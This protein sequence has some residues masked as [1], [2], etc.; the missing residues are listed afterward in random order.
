MIAGLL[1]TRILIDYLGLNMLGQLGLVLSISNILVSVGNAISGAISRYFTLYINKDEKK[2]ATIISSAIALNTYLFFGI[3]IFCL[4]ISDNIFFY[5]I[6]LFSF[7]LNQ[8]SGILSSGNFYIRDFVNTSTINI[9]SRVI[10]VVLLYVTLRF[11]FTD[12]LAVA[13]SLIISSIYKISAFYISFQK[14]FPKI[15]I[16]NSYS[17]NIL[18]ELITFIGWMLLTY[19][20]MY[21]IRMGIFVI[22]DKY[23]IS[24]LGYYS[25]L[26][27]ISTVVAQILGTVTV[28]TSPYIYKH[29]SYN[30]NKTAKEYCNLFVNIANIGVIVAI[31]LNCIIGKYAFNLW[32]GKNISDYIYPYVN[33]VIIS[34]YIATLCIPLSVYLAGINKIKIYGIVTI[35]ESACVF[36]LTSL[37]YY[38]SDNADFRVLFF[39]LGVCAFAK[40]FIIVPSLTKE[41]IFSIRNSINFIIQPYILIFI[42]IN[43]LLLILSIF[44]HSLAI[45]LFCINIIYFYIKYKNDILNIK[46]Q[47]VK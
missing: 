30:D 13:L 32:L 19:L 8:I 4:F 44:S 5:I 14:S 9:L 29:I 45:I 23:C 41:K 37:Y 1:A 2:V 7:Y 25:I 34:S 35:C 22:I 40:I 28:I 15:K 33:W 27:Q 36:I 21:I 43:I 42:L 3:L 26:N 10:Y 39:I 17:K 16:I 47:N 31:I 11:W 46:E 24:Q 6:V 18:I 20:G 38:L 12:L